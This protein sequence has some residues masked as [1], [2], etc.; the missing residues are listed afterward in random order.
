MERAFS[1]LIF[2]K[3]VKGVIVVTLACCPQISLAKASAWQKDISD[4][5]TSISQGNLKR[6]E[7]CFRRALQT[8]VAAHST[9]DEAQCRNKLANALALE[10]K[11]EE[12]QTL[13]KRSLITL[14][15]TYGK[16]SVK[17]VPTLIALGSFLEA[18]GDHNSAMALY[19]RAIAIN[20][21]SYGR[22]S[23]AMTATVRHSGL[24][25][26]SL[27]ATTYKPANRPLNEQAGLKA[28]ARLKQSVPAPNDLLIKG[29][30]SNQELLSAFRRE[31]MK[32][33]IS[34]KSVKRRSAWQPK[35]FGPA[36]MRTY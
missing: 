13:Y 18:E 22:Y 23:P 21:K 12:A 14:E 10:G 2:S 17:I 4:G 11:T 3:V 5:E 7:L 6:A 27:G 8:T 30:D 31:T 29:D 16:S 25:L 32:T 36:A 26:H 15:H 28:S 24:Q 20:E 33:E 9:K 34:D 19:Q 1:R 35:L